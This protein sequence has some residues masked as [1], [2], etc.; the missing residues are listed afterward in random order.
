MPRKI[1]GRE[2]FSNEVMSKFDDNFI[3]EAY[4][5]N[6]EGYG[7]NTDIFSKFG[8]ETKDEALT[9]SRKMETFIE[10]FLESLQSADAGETLL[11]RPREGDV[12]FFPL[13]ERMFE[14]KYVEHENP[15]Y[16]LGKNYVYELKCEL[17]QL[18]DSEIL[19]LL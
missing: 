6:V 5:N 3:I 2:T 1:L 14:I 13:G 17:L 16:Q 11:S 19:K 12:I 8:I 10:P 18:S 7:E 15:F 4:L 9:I